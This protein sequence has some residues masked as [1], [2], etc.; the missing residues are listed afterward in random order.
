MSLLNPREELQQHVQFLCCLV[1]SGT[2]LQDLD[3]ETLATPASAGAAATTTAAV[4]GRALPVQ[5]GALPA[6]AAAAT[7][8]A[9]GTLLPLLVGVV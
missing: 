8:G 1:R 6:L 2:H 5:H 7:T 3:P 4:A 9:E